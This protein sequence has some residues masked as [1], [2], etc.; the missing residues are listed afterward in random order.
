[1]NIVKATRKF[2]AW[3]GLHTRIVNDDLELKHQRMAESL[4]C[5]FRATFYRWAQTWPEISGSLNRAPR[6][7]AVGDLHIENFGTWRD[8]DGRL[9]WGINDFDEVHSLPYAIDLVRLT[10]SALLAK[11]ETHLAINPRTAATAILQGYRQSMESG[12]RPFVLGEEHAWLRTIAESELRDPV[13]FWRKMDRLPETKGDVPTSAREAIEHML[14]ETGLNYRLSKRVAGLG[15]LGHMRFV[16]VATWKG[17]RV[18]REAKALT[19]SSVY[20]L[21]PDDG[22]G[23]ILYSEV[24]RRAI[25]CPD[26]YVQMRGH[27]IVR[28]L[29]PHCSRIRLDTLDKNRDEL[30]LLEAMGWETANVHLGSLGQRKA[31]V[32]D[33]RR[34]KGNW[35]LESAQ[36]MVKTV[37]K[38]WKRWKEHWVKSQPTE[39]RHT[40]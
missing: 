9:V 25:R 28:R 18:A 16:A 15:S 4:F 21:K 36:S 32:Q 11:Q 22:P 14:P 12:G 1:M 10:A 31:I 3:L 23:D 24:L 5:F 33:L 6:V 27:W 30:K 2:E 17:G 20:W 7:L 8:R 38:D 13:Q 35:L 39:K 19:P 34:R 40:H 37:E 26:P 29:S